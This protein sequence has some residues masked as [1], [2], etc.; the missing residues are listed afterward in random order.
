[1]GD[2]LATLGAKIS[3][4][5]VRG[6]SVDGEEIG[7]SF[8]N[9]AELNENFIN[10]Y[11]SQGGPLQGLIGTV[12]LRLQTITLVGTEKLIIT[13]EKYIKSMDARHRQ[14]ALSI[15][16]I[17]VS[18][19]KNDIASNAF[20]VTKGGS[21]LIVNSGLSI[22][23]GNNT[24][25]EPAAGST[26]NAFNSGTALTNN[27]F[28]NWIQTKLTNENAKLMASPTLILGENSDAMVSGIASATGGLDSAAIGRPFA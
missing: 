19:T 8:V 23:T 18:L 25:R 5:L 3:K 1:M 11:G 10:S 4:V 7:N 28:L 12:D 6:S 9:K 26:V 21:T 22:I 15:K 14:V 24:P 27:Q 16:I 2:Y 13:A 20:D 17:D